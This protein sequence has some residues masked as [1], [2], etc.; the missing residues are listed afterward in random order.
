M[1]GRIKDLVEITPVGNP[2]VDGQSAPE[3]SIASF[4]LTYDLGDALT[5]VVER[6]A[7][8][9]G[10]PK[11]C[12]IVGSSGCGKST[13]LS[14]AAS[15]LEVDPKA[16]MHSRLT[17]IRTGLGDLT[18]H[19]VRITD[20][21]KTKRLASTIERSIIDSFRSSG[22][23]FRSHDDTDSSGA[24]LDII[25]EAALSLPEKHRLIIV[26]DDLDG[27]LRGAGRYAYDNLQTMVIG[28]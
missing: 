1:S 11:N 27:W 18:A 6:L 10:Q 9:T 23:S 13:L 19:V 25:A 3:R 5:R 4:L 26:I 24:W 2:V 8:L 17:E 14:V 21:G 12:L 22:L 7:G 28:G 16:E 20:T 15:L